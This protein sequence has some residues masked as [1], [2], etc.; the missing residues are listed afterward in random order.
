[1]SSFALR[2]RDA[3]VVGVLGPPCEHRRDP[4][5]CLSTRGGKVVV[6]KVYVV[7]G[8]TRGVAGRTRCRRLRTPARAREGSSPRRRHR[9]HRRSHGS[10]ERW[11]SG[12]AIAGVRSCTVERVRG[13]TG[14]DRLLAGSRGMRSPS[15]PCGPRTRGGEGKTEGRRRKT[16]SF[17]MGLLLSCRGLL[18]WVP[19][20]PPPSVEDPT[21]KQPRG[22]SLSLRGL[23]YPTGGMRACPVARPYATIRPPPKG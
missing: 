16:L 14:G 20:I 22:L 9:R 1:V 2:Y 10:P 18:H 5:A 4:G 12:S 7:R 15:G 19:L 3:H 11:P 8:R 6:R 17:R 21:L 13:G 23:P